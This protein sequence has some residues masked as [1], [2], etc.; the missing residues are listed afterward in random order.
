MPTH[1]WFVVS[2]VT[3]AD[4]VVIVNVSSDDEGLGD[5]DMLLAA[6]HPWLTHDSYIRT[7]RALLATVASLKAGTA[8]KPAVLILQAPALP[9]CLVKLQAALVKSAHTRREIK[10]VLQEQS[11]PPAPHV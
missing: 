5:L 8:S 2:N 7:D 10:R 3:G 11:L 9:G 6:D 4:R 1:L